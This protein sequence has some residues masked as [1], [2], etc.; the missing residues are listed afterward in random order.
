MVVEVV[1]IV[2]LYLVNAELP[3]LTT[4]LPAL[5][6]AL[7]LVVPSGLKTTARLALLILAVAV[8]MEKLTL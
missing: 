4:E 1:V 8:R 5:Q 3:M 7:L 6:V 2:Q